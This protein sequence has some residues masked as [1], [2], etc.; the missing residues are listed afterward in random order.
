MLLY[1]FLP[2]NHCDCDGVFGDDGDNY[3][4]DDESDAYDYDDDSCVLSMK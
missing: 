3:D 4:D 2:N 1:L